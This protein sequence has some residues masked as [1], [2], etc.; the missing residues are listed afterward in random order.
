MIKGKLKFEPKDEKE[1][2]KIQ[3][4]LFSIGG[5]WC[6][7]KKNVQHTDNKYLY[8]DSYKNITYGNEQANFRKWTKYREMTYLDLK[9]YVSSKNK[10][11]TIFGKIIKK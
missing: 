8:F 4:L 5:I 11:Y 10:K 1:N 2:A 9:L 3:K 6:T 7:R